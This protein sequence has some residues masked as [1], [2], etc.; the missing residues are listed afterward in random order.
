[1]TALVPAQSSVAELGHFC[2]HLTNWQ[3]GCPLWSCTEEEK[4]VCEP[5]TR[6]L[7]ARGG[8]VQNQPQLRQGQLGLNGTQ[9][10][11]NNIMCIVGACPVA[12]PARQLMF[13]SSDLDVVSGKANLK[14]SVRL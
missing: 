12:E 4:A 2:L 11:N 6:G 1:M 14:V 5:S 8:G 9:S 13:L 3:K 7:E 10:Q